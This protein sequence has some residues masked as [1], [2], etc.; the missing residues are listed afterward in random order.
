MT[1][2]VDPLLH[3]PPRIEAQIAGD[4]QIQYIQYIKMWISH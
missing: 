4:L 3:K 2:M 1:E